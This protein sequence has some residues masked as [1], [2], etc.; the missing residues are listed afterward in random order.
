MRRGTVLDRLYGSSRIR[1]RLWKSRFPLS[2]KGLIRQLAADFRCEP[3]EIE[4]A[5][6]EIDRGY[7]LYG[8]AITTDA[9][10]A[11]EYRAL[12]HAIPDLREDEDFVTK[13]HTE[14]WKALRRTLP[15]GVARRGAGAVSRL[16]AV[17]RLKEI[18]V[19][20]GFRRAGG[21]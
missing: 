21:G 8:R 11:D 10:L 18:M 7:P 19:L 15:T 13:H 4:A 17:D 9:L 6:R 16:V 5:I 2:R 12:V 14:D 20:E 3:D 1:E